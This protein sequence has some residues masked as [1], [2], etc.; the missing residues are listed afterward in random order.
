MKKKPV[1][2]LNEVLLV[3][4]TLHP[5]KFLQGCELKLILTVPRKFN[6]LGAIHLHLEGQ[7]ANA[8]SIKVR[9]NVNERYSRR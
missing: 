8:E 6:E 7:A 5:T 1:L 4:F 9:A 3:L 2:L